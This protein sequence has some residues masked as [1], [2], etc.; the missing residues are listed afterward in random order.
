MNEYGMESIVKSM[1]RSLRNVKNINKR[2]SLNE[3][4]NGIDDEFQNMIFRSFIP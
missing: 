4:L 3:D 1:V 2:N